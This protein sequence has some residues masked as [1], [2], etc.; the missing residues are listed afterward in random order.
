M[1]SSARSPA[2]R[3][4]RSTGLRTRPRNRSQWPAPREFSAERAAAR[5]HG[6]RD[7]KESLAIGHFQPL[8]DDLAQRLEDSINR[9][10]RACA[11]VFG[12]REA[13]AV[14]QL[15]NVA[16]RIDPDQKERDLLE[17]RPLQCRD[18]MGGLFE[19]GAELTRKRFQIVAARVDGL[20]KGGIR[21]DD[22]GGGVSC[23]CAARQQLG[24][25]ARELAGFQRRIDLIFHFEIGELLGQ[26]EVEACGVERVL[27]QEL[28]V[29]QVQRLTDPSMTLGGR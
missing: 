6:A 23:E 11:A 28:L 19:A 1:G 27:E 12:K 25:L 18:A 16:G 10:Q 13:G 29:M 7:R 3:R 9:P 8:R 21:H 26:L 15:G 20:R 2:H 5:G 4:Y 24:A 22:R 17:T 14:E